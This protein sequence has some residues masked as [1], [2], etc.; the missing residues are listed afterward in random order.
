MPPVYASIMD[1]VLPRMRGTMMAYYTL[2]TTILGLGTGPYL[3]GLISDVT[4]NLGGA[5]L[6]TFL[7][8]PAIV[9]LTIYAVLRM[10]RDEASL[11]ERARAAGENC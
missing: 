1:L 3:V 4:G 7:V 10:P 5:I 11:L 8:S 6:A 2:I 9:L